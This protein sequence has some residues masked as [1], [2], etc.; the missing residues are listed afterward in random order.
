MKP[1]SFIGRYLSP[2]Y[3]E[4]TIT[5]IAKT[6]EN[7]RSLLSVL[8]DYMEHS[9]IKIKEVSSSCSILNYHGSRMSVTLMIAIARS[10]EMDDIIKD[11]IGRDLEINLSEGTVVV[12]SN[13]AG[14]RNIGRIRGSIAKIAKHMHVDLSDAE[15]TLMSLY[16]RKIH[17]GACTENEAQE[18]EGFMTM[19]CISEG[20]LID[21]PPREIIDMYA[22][23]ARDKN[24]CIVCRVPVYKRVG[25]WPLCYQH[26]GEVNKIG[27]NK[28]SEKYIL[29]D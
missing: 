20:I 7:I 11:N 23:I 26:Y 15:D 9:T 2:I 5:I 16:G 21:R 1:V 28:F 22:K 17:W 6:E 14:R 12:E 10:P 13:I 3:R 18:F 24:I 25:L 19:F 27:R 29:G 4:K 8:Y